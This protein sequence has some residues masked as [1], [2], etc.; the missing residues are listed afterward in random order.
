MASY[1]TYLVRAGI[2]KSDGKGGVVKTGDNITDELA[3][4]MLDQCIERERNDKK[5]TRALQEEL[6]LST[7]GHEGHDHSGHHDHG[8]D[9][10][11]D[12]FHINNARL[13]KRLKL[14]REK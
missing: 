12:T 5:R 7:G 11:T 6:G 14:L 9:H 2:I 13:E 10:H 3:Q 4:K 8:H 1:I